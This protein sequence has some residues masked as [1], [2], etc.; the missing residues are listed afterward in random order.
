[1]LTS[2]VNPLGR[3]ACYELSMVVIGRSMD[4]GADISPSL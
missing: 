3:L 1:M 2:G 4:I